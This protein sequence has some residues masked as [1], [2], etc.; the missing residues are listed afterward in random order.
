MT[1]SPIRRYRSYWLVIHLVQA[2]G[3]AGAGD[4]SASVSPAV[5][6]TLACDASASAGVHIV[7]FHI[8][9]VEA[10]AAP[11]VVNL[12]AVVAL[13]G[14]QVGA[15]TLTKSA[16][17][18][19]F[20]HTYGRILASQDIANDSPCQHLETELAL[21]WLLSPFLT[22]GVDAD[23]WKGVAFVTDGMVSSPYVASVAA[24]A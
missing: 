10:D 17:V 1:E 8:V 16:A 19:S 5:H 18:P 11:K 12:I 21:D 22:F 9:A 6:G 4:T 3:T 23:A 13:A 15:R 24:V 20:H 14:V 2:P 7:A